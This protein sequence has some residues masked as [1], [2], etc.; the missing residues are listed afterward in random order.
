MTLIQKIKRE[1][2]FN[3][4]EYLDHLGKP[5]IGY[6]TL[7]PLNDEESTLLLEHRLHKMME[8]L[9]KAKPFIVHLDENRQNA[10]YEMAYQLGVRGLLNFSKMW[11]ALERNNYAEASAQ[12]LDSIWAKQTPN[13]AKRVAE[14]IK[15][16]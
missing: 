5:T 10:L 9:H 15:N 3:G 11:E 6:G 13:R 7:L 2:G 12:A 16:G 1:E 14:I 8:A 4:R